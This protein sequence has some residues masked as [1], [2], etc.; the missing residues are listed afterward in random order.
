LAAGASTR[1]SDIAAV[2]SFLEAIPAAVPSLV[3]A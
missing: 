3:E 2:I 1:E